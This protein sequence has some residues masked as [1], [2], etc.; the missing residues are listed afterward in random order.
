MFRR[1]IIHSLI[2]FCILSL[3]SCNG[4]DHFPK[5]PVRKADYLERSS[6]YKV[7]DS[8]FW[9]APSNKTFW[10][11][12]HRV[13]FKSNEALAPGPDYKITVWDTS[14]GEV[15]FSHPW[16]KGSAV[17]CVK[18]GQV[19][20][21]T[22]NQKNNKSTFYRGPLDQLQPCPRPNKNMVIDERMD[23]D[24]EYRSGQYESPGGPYP[25]EYRLLGMNYLRVVGR[26]DDSNLA[27]QTNAVRMTQEDQSIKEDS[28]ALNTLKVVYYERPGSP[29]VVLPVQFGRRGD[30]G[31]Y[32]IQYIKWKNAYFFSPGQYYENIVPRVWWLSPHGKAKEEK[33]PQNLPFTTALISFY[34]VRAGLFVTIGGYPNEPG[35]YLIQD[36]KVTP[37][38]KYPVFDVS[39]SPDGCKAAFG[40][41]T[42]MR[43]LG[44]GYDKDRTIKMIDFCKNEVTK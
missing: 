23:C 14:T 4:N 8:G 42:N 41:T 17:I 31:F 11:D 38:I 44:H 34:P 43:K 2:L 29:G 35:A 24:W 39:I 28:S 12:N 27:P 5:P 3:F 36:G 22:R 1:I 6:D 7:V 26:M 37:L 40:H 10:L 15:S 32:N 20:Y 13:M 21:H 33:L 25:Y 30:C 19:F 18:D 16:E 9:S